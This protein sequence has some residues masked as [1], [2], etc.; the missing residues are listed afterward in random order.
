MMRVFVVLESF[1]LKKNVDML[2]PPWAVQNFFSVS[3]CIQFDNVVRK[4]GWRRNVL[5]QEQ[6]HFFAG[7][8][9][10]DLDLWF[11]YRKGQRK[12]GCWQRFERISAYYYEAKKGRIQECGR[13]GCREWRG[14]EDNVCVNKP[15]VLHSMVLGAKNDHLEQV[16]GDHACNKFSTLSY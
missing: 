5:V 11:V 12:E 15:A 10:W 1:D 6:G 13:C 7:G 14:R 2:T 4:V 16:Q 9:L 3:L 8:G